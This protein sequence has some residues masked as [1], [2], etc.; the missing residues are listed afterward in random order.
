MY[1]APNK[2]TEEK[3]IT[4]QKKNSNFGPRKKKIDVLTN[5][6]NG[7]FFDKQTF[8]MEIESDK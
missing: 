4:N 2:R 3:L 1:L 5:L 6:W 8:E 7:N